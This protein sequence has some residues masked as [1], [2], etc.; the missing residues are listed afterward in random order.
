MGQD[1][2]GEPRKLLR[3]LQTQSGVSR[4]K[5]QELIEAGELELNGAVVVDPFLAVK[6]GSVTAL[7]LR[8][9]P[10]SSLP[11]ESRAYRYHK[12]IGMLCSHDDPHYGNTVGR[13]LR[14]EGFIGY[15]WAGRLDQDSE[16]LILLANDGWIVHRL[17][18]PRY[19]VRK[20]YH[21]WL[22]R[23]PPPKTM[24]RVFD[25]MH[26][27]IDD[28]GERLRIVRGSLSGRPTHAVLTLT[29]GKKREIRRLFSHFDLEVVRLRR[30]SIGPVKLGSLASGAFARLS[31]DEMADLHDA[32]EPQPPRSRG[33]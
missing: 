13:V 9:H 24:N 7:R 11:P 33:D 27:G 3:V 1:R 32:I 22:A 18:H 10:L 23:T 12:P 26:Q 21:V 20:S 16:G 31:P 8:G 4:R 30:V 14:A 15:T 5:A 29:E 2:D 25:A 19:E 17:T 28:R 6:A